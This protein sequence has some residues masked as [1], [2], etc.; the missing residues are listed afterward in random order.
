[1]KYIVRYTRNIEKRIQMMPLRERIK[2]A[3]L[4]DALRS[5]GPVQPSW[6]N[7]GKLSATKYHCHLSYHW[8]ACWRREQGS[9]EIE[10]YYAGNRE[11]APY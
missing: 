8:V 1:M 11:N 7:Y 6:P 9:I 5:S 10:V 4:I 3:A 2:M